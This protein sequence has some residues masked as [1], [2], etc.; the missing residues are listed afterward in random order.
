MGVRLQP[1]GHVHR[2]AQRR[3]LDPVAG[4][5]RPR[6][7]GSRVDADPHVEGVDTPPFGDL[8]PN[9][10][11]SSTMRR[12]A[13]TA[14]SASSSC[15]V[16]A[17]KSARTPSPARSSNTLPCAAPLGPIVLLLHG[18]SVRLEF[19]SVGATENVLMAS[20]LATGH[21]R[22]ENA[23]RE[24]EIADIAKV[25]VSM[26]AHVS[27]AGTSTIEIDGVD[28]LHAT[29]YHVVP[30]RIAAGSWAFAAATTR[31]D[32]EVVGGRAE[33]LEISLDLLTGAGSTVT[34]TPDGFRVVGPQGRPR[35]VDVATLPYAGFPTDLQPFAL[36]YNAVADGS[37][38]ITENLFEARFRTVQ[39]WP[40]SE[41]TPGSTATTSWSTASRCCRVRRSRPATSAP[42]QRSSS[43][44]SSRT[45]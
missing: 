1:G 4:A 27:G 21:T 11:M 33:H 15:A 29:E 13:R 40:A 14:R 7:D 17:P 34:V 44:V 35:S 31:G 30:D 16:G 36:T 12:P 6:D 43:R 41:P 38:M 24:P 10:A 42:V 2:V 26:G 22:I 19:P 18:A 9:V 5:D 37:A 32:V 25:R 45:G 20:V 3:E 23:A 28:A 8:S 39:G